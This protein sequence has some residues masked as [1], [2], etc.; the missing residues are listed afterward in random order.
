MLDAIYA[1]GH[2]NN[3]KLL[4]DAL[5][6]IETFDQNLFMLYD[7]SLSLC[8]FT[9]PIPI[10]RFAKE[11]YHACLNTYGKNVCEDIY[12]QIEYSDIEDEDT[13]MDTKGKGKARQVDNP[14]SSNALQSTSSG[15]PRR[16]SDLVRQDL[17]VSHLDDETDLTWSC[18]NDSDDEV[19]LQSLSPAE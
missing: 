3:G 15:P 2:D 9:S 17:I 10:H 19:V 4:A 11:I 5:L 12:G 6:V 8:Q 14:M 1:I 13:E 18:D 16:M 7:W